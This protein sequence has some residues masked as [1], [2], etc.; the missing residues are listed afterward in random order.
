MTMQSFTVL[1]KCIIPL[2]FIPCRCVQM[3]SVC[4]LRKGLF[5]S[6]S[7]L[8]LSF[9]SLSLFAGSVTLCHC[10]S[11]CPRDA[12]LPAS[13][14]LLHVSPVPNRPS[15]RGWAYCDGCQGIAP[16]PQGVSHTDI[17]P[18]FV[19]QPF[20]TLHWASRVYLKY[21]NLKANSMS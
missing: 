2:S 15:A 20:K 14:P 8:S 5:S 21:H 12:A 4:P 17:H 10:C 11:R 7:L 1:T 16:I 13:I 3:S 6:C 18:Q 9:L 19:T